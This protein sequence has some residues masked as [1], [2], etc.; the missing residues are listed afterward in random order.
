MKKI[1]YIS[2]A[3]LIAGCATTDPNMNRDKT[4]K[5]AATGAAIGAIAGAIIG[6]NNDRS[7][8]AL[9]GALLGAAAGGI[10]GGS[11][12]SYMDKQQYEFE[13]QL[14]TERATHQM[15]IER[16]QNENLK[17]TMSGEV[18]F[19]FNSAALKPNF[20]DTL[21]KIVDILQ[22]YPQTTIEITGHTD[23]VGSS[24]YNQQLSEQRAISVGRYLKKH[25]IDA[26]RI[27]T[28][29]RGEWDPRATN[30]TEA[31]RQLNRRVEILIIPV[32]A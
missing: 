23:S 1:A 9:R 4:K 21:D 16:L 22:R 17:L 5:G 6:H 28:D 30:D 18:S 24:E 20:H 8:G 19:A 25:G 2:I 10:A 32:R 7:G 31:G 29:G 15:Q 13:Q 12:G 14:A 11:I 27:S 26:S 3:L